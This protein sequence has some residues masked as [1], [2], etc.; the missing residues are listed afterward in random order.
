LTIEGGG[1]IVTPAMTFMPDRQEAG[2]RMAD[3]AAVTIETLQGQNALLRQ[4]LHGAMDS[5]LTV[6]ELGRTALINDAASRTFGYS[7]DEFLHLTAAALFPSNG[8]NGGD[9][10]VVRAL[11]SR[12]TWF[13]EGVARR[14]DGSTFPALLFLS[15]VDF[16]KAPAP[17]EVQRAAD[18]SGR[19]GAYSILYVRDMAEQQRL[20][21][22]LKYLSI[23]DDLTGVYNVRYFWARLRYE[24]V[25]SIRY[26]QP[27]SCL[28]ADLD[29]FK[30]V[31]DKYGHRTGDEVLQR[32]ARTMSSSVR[33]V[34]IL[35]RYGGEEF[36]IILPNTGAPGAAKCAENV[37]NA[38]AAAD[39][40]V[41]QAAIRVTVSIGAAVLTPEVRNE[42]QLAVRADEGLICAK[43]Q[44]RNRVCVWSAEASEAIV[45]SPPKAAPNA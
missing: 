40:S 18:H 23:T 17:G 22:R 9:Q 33:E 44:G 37:R 34:D 28:M 45:L 10:E 5:I 20:V 24:Y 6:D 25:R 29:R 4:I 7:S 39:F 30:D 27:L 35:A 41:G 16:G 38:V 15:C 13:G 43:R 2:R 11:A 42:E 14:K 32:V 8:P 12:K 19:A 3:D 21:D 36:G 31:N 1:G 26:A